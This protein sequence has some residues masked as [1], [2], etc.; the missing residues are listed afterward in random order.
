MS[1]CCVVKWQK[2]SILAEC[3]ADNDF[4]AINPDHFTH[5]V[6]SI[7]TKDKPLPI[8][9]KEK[10]I[11]ILLKAHLN[12][13][14][15]SQNACV[16]ENI[17][18]GNFTMFVDI[19]IPLQ[20]YDLKYHLKEVEKVLSEFSI[21]FTLTECLISQSTKDGNVYSRFQWPNL[22]VNMHMALLI[23]ERIVHSMDKSVDTPS[24]DWHER[25]QY[26]MYQDGPTVLES[27]EIN[28]CKDCKKKDAS[29][30]CRMCS[31]GILPRK[32][33]AYVVDGEEKNID[34]EKDKMAWLEKCMI[35]KPTDLITKGCLCPPDTPHYL[36]K[37]QD[38]GSGT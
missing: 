29:E 28:K 17:Q 22:I 2:M 10:N 37:D 30:I 31:N 9:L 7:Y 5:T 13:I 4:E 6:T 3:I 23:R 26:K 32:L 11:K 36:Y 24:I 27:A 18:L 19:I 25:I 15:Q 21:G 12:G 16:R 20:E 8:K 1:D 14:A 38:K 34:F 33:I 35:A